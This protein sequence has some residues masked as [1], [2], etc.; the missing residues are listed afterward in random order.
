MA[1]DAIVTL[2]RLRCIRESDGSGHSE[3]YIWPVLIWI[4]TTNGQVNT[5]DLVL[6]NARI[7]IDHDMRAGQVVLIPS[8]VNT[9]RVRF[10]DDPQRFT[11]IISV[12]LWENDETPED[13][14]RAGFKA[15]TSELR[16]AI[17]ANL[18]ALQ[19]AQGNPA[20]EEAVKAT[21]EKRVKDKVEAGIK[22]A[23][24]TGQ[25]IRIA[26]GTL[27]MDDVVG[28]DSENLGAISTLATTKPFT[29]A[30]RNKSGSES[31]EIEGNL[32]VKPVPVDLCQAQVDAV[33][34][35]QAAVDGVRNEIRQLQAELHD[36]SPQQK[37]GII[38]MIKKLQQDDLADANTALQKAKQAL[39]ACRDRPV[40][41]PPVFDPGGGVLTQ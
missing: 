13:A 1:T 19:A 20:E 14:M 23:L 31:Y 29:L 9:L 27:N 37:P 7:V 33:K 6:G 3:P 22:G 8:S 16:A 25:K 35:A 36:A 11:F 21:I 15:Y 4:D 26:L 32:A 12:V 18:L 41:R 24:T 34:A 5:A 39:Q 17:I 38:A 40:H 2:E 28:S 10:T 30:F